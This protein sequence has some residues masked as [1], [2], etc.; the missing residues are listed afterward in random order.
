MPRLSNPA[1]S[2]HGLVVPNSFR[3]LMVMGRLGIV[4]TVAI[5]ECARLVEDE[6]SDSDSRDGCEHWDNRLS[7]HRKI[8][9]W[10]YRSSY[11]AT[12]V[13]G[14]LRFDRSLPK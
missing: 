6:G 11:H 1:S 14:R 5:V 3:D 2:T 7:D 9:A 8:P 13:R 12:G 4:H 10:Q